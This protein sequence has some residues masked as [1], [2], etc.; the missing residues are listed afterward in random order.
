VLSTAFASQSLIREFEPEDVILF[1]S[2]GTAKTSLFSSND[3]FAVIR[4]HDFSQASV[5]IVQSHN[6]AIISFLIGKL[7]ASHFVH[8][9]NMEIIA[10]QESMISQYIFLFSAG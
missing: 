10:H 4:V 2:H 9:Q 5:I 6:H 7:Y 8:G 1:I 3:N